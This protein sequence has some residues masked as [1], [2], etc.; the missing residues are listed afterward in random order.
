MPYGSRRTSPRTSPERRLYFHFLWDY[1]VQW[2]IFENGGLL[3]YTL[4]G[5]KYGSRWGTFW[6][7]TKDLWVLSYELWHLSYDLWLMSYELWNLYDKKTCLSV[8]T[9]CI[10]SA[11]F[12]FC[13]Q[14]NR[15]WHF[16]QIA[17]NP[18]TYFSG[19]IRTIFYNVTC[20]KFTQHVNCFK[21]LIK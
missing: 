4:Q 6:L 5:V 17:W 3:M 18:K 20:W 14:G 1:W 15:F 2:G 13:F 21:S 12:S 16:M 7:A 8:T 19:K 9:S 10:Y 11:D